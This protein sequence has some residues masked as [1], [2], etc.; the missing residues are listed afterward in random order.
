MKTFKGAQAAH[1]LLTAPMGGLD[2]QIIHK[3]RVDIE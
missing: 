2:M 3:S 1:L